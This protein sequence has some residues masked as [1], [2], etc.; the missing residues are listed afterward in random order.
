[1]STKR[2]FWTLLLGIQSLLLFVSQP[3]LADEKLAPPQQVIQQVS[4]Q[5][6]EV[7]AND[8][9]RLKNDP[10]YVYQ[11]ANEILL[12]HIDFQR[13][14]SLVLGKHWLRAT[15]EQ[16]Q[17]FSAQFQ[18]L[19]VRTYS[20]AVYQFQDWTIRYLPLRY[21]KDGQHVEVRTE[22]LQPNTKPVAVD[23][24]LH[25]QNGHWM[26]YDVKIEGVS[27]VTNYRSSFQNHIR[28]GGIDYLIQQLH[29]LNQR[30][31]P[32]S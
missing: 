2:L 17:E 31:A 6:R 3:L 16:Q 20:S 29:E 28:R 24:R 12:P 32:S 10:D 22:I 21:S 7:L 23:Y 13:T 27:L 4:D 25:Q 1:M 15:K 19:L 26:A 8:R 30:P 5:L 11:L 14:A 9:D 18:K